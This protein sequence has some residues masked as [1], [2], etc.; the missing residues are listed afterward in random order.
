M[1]LRL[2]AKEFNLALFMIVRQVL[3]PYFWS[4]C[5]RCSPHLHK[6]KHMFQKAYE[7]FKYNIILNFTW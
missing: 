2:A 5:F 4:A 3:Y 7:S 6:N 1:Q